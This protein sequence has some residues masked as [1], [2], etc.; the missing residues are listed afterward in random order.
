MPGGGGRIGAAIAEELGRGG[1]F[2]VTVDPRVTATVTR[3]LGVIPSESCI[4][5][6]RAIG[7]VRRY[8]T[9]V[10]VRSQI[11]PPGDPEHCAWLGRR[12]DRSTPSFCATPDLSVA[13]VIEVDGTIVESSLLNDAGEF[14]VIMEPDG[15]AC[16]L[17]ESDLRERGAAWATLATHVRT[18]QRTGNGF[19]IVYDSKATEALRSLVAAERICCSWATWTCE[20][21]DEGEV[22][23]VTGP[24]EPIGALADAFDV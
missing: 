2:V 8:P 4:C 19:R 17:D 20:T 12:A 5:V 18:S 9:P 13:T 11:A 3:Y 24:A 14:G 21:T 16:D 23:E 6:S 15:F 1:W 7:A 10:A 22:M